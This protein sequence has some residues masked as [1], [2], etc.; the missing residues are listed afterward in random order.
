MKRYI[1]A[2]L[3][4][5]VL[6]TVCFFFNLVYGQSLDS[7]NFDNQPKWRVSFYAAAAFGGP[8]NQIENA[9]RA[10]GLND[11]SYNW[12]SGEK[13]SYPHSEATGIP[14]MIET[15]YR[16]NKLFSLGFQI[17]NSVIQETVGFARPQGGFGNFLRLNYSAQMYA[18]VISFYLDEHFTFGLGPSFNTLKLNA[19]TNVKK[20]KLGLEA[21]LNWEFS[22]FSFASGNLIFQY[23]YTGG[24]NIGPFVMENTVGIATPTPS[25]VT[26][27]FPLT[28]V[29][30]SHW[31]IG[32]GTSFHF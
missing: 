13:I 21:F 24:M 20:N 22:L 18:L 4:K 12:F 3:I 1:S 25:T 29:D 31:L 26:I 14:W 9:M 19:T 32:F 2:I 23:R 27:T 28:E 30:Y 8:S 11:E 17:S 15:E 6:I 5:T 16:M 7:D 10:S